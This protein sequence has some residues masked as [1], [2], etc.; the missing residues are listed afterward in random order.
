MKKTKILIFLVVLFSMVFALAAKTSIGNEYSFFRDLNVEKGDTIEGF[1][2][3]IGADLKVDGIISGDAMVLFGKLSVKGLIKGNAAGIGSSIII[4][5][6]GVVGGD[7][8]AFMGDVISGEKAIINGTTSEFGFPLDFNASNFIPVITTALVV[9]VLVIYFLACMIYLLVPKRVDLISKSLDLFF[10]RRL[11]IG[12]LI[13]LALIPLIVVLIVTIVG[14]IIIPIVIIVYFSLNM[15]GGVAVFLAIG[16]KVSG[17]GTCNPYICI[18][19]GL[20]VLYILSFIPIVGWI[21]FA[22]ISMMSLGAAVDTRLG[23]VE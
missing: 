15:L 20:L 11:L 16:K 10:W 6:S 17:G 21:F 14:I 13:N 18:M 19:S 22:G 12:F 4:G 3:V 7:A 23:M 5:N 2:L 1:C 8:A 9:L